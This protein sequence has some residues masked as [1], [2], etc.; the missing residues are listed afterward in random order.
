VALHNPLF[1][2]AIFIVGICALV[3]GAA[4]IFLPL[5]PTT[6]FVLLAAW[7]FLKSS[8]KAYDWIYNRSVFGPILKN[9]EENQVIETRVKF[10]A[11]GTILVSLIIMWIKVNILWLKVAVTLGLTLVST[12]ILTR[13]SRRGN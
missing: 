2:S 1:K 4:G 10:L 13:K 9:W 3:L 8:P 6:P 11:C 7:C 12:F 5:L